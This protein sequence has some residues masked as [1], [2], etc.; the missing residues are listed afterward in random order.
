MFSTANPE[1]VCDGGIHAVH[2]HNFIV[3]SVLLNHP[4]VMNILMKT[5]LDL[6]HVKCFYI[7][8][9][10]SIEQNAFR[11]TCLTEG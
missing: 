10:L 7:D 4:C 3:L 9:V 1:R 5:N 6:P 8:C 11:D 2:L